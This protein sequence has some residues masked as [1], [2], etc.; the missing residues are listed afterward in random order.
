MARSG[1]TQKYVADENID[2]PYRPLMVKK[3]YNTKQINK[4]LKIHV[5][6]TKNV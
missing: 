2:S 6:K 1:A 4:Y 5:E 3:P